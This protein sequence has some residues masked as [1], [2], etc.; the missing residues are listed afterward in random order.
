MEESLNQVNKTL[1]WQE[2]DNTDS[3]KVN[4]YITVKQSNMMNNIE[5]IFK[6]LQTNFWKGFTIMKKIP[7]SVSNSFKILF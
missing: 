5:E 6:S 4:F 2:G 7:L 3:H 1:S